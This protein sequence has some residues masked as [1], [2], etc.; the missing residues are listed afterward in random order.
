MASTCSQP[1]PPSYPH[2]SIIES[3]LQLLKPPPSD[4]SLFGCAARFDLSSMDVPASMD[5]GRFQAPP[6]VSQPLPPAC[7][8]ELSEDDSDDDDD[9]PTLRQILDSPK[10][11]KQVI[12]LTRNNDGDSE[13]DDG[14]HT[15]VSWLRYTR[16]ARH[17]MTLT[18]PPWQTASRS[19]TNSLYPSPSPLPKSPAHTADDLTASLTAATPGRKEHPWVDPPSVA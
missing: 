9:L 17:R 7:A 16:R 18:S 13:G 5:G 8:A 15:E 12:D 10:Q 6:A 19:L 1:N 11:A 14:N 3:G 4:A 2:S